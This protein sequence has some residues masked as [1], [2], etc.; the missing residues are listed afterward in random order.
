MKGPVND[1]QLRSKRLYPL[2]AP[3]D[4]STDLPYDCLETLLVSVEGCKVSMIP[5]KNTSDLLPD[6]ACNWLEYQGYVDTGGGARCNRQQ[7]W[8]GIAGCDG[9]AGS[10]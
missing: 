7:A 2:T 9:T 8:V 6:F 1:C 4:F 5:M 10:C 3:M